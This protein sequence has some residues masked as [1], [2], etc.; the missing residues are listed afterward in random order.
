MEIFSVLEIQ[1]TIF[2]SPSRIISYK[3]IFFYT[4]KAVDF[5]CTQENMQHIQVTTCLSTANCQVVLQSLT[6]Q[7]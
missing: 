2:M 3:G 6:C 1:E 7:N 5:Y 4:S